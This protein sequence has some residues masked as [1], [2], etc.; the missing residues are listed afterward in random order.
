[1]TMDWTTL[2]GLVAGLVLTVVSIVIDGEIGPF[3]HLP[4]AVLV[5]GGSLAATVISF[6]AEQL[7]NVPAVLRVAFEK[8]THPEA[9]VVERLVGLAQ[10]ARREGLLAL[11]DEVDPDEDPF[12]HRGLQLVVD[13]ADPEMVRNIL[14]IELIALE[15][16]H[17]MG[18]SMF[19][20]LGTY[21]PAFGM[22]GTLVGLIQML[23]SLD[24][25]SQLG[26]AMALAIL[27]TLYGVLLANLVFLPIAAKLKLKSNKEIQLNEVVVEGILSIQ[28]GENPRIIERKLS[29]FLGVKERENAA[30]SSEEP[31]RAAIADVS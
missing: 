19:Q 14:E 6:S 4:S 12:L 11:E 22:M 28:A 31:R 21:A 9:R 29:A 30:Q 8:R 10:K 16:R 7:R 24:D 26:P 20:T 13:G 1:M 27:T 17:R 25:P 2:L 18:Q 5:L 23:R 15:E 3:L